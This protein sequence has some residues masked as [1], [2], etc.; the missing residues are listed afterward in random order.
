MRNSSAKPRAAKR[1]GKRDHDVFGSPVLDAMPDLIFRMNKEG[2]YLNFKPSKELE[3][4]VPPSEFLGRKMSDVLPSDVAEEGMALIERAIET[5]KTQ[6]YEYQLPMGEVTHTYEARI[7]ALDND[8]VLVI[9]RDISETRPAKSVASKPTAQPKNSYGLTTREFAVL[10]LL[11]GGLTDKE[12]GRQLQISP[13][14]ARKHVAN[15]RRKMGAPSRTAAGVR[16][17]REGLAK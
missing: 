10:R 9:V 7:V 13:E 5:G 2:R 15:L 16:A 14:T 12:I 4:Y 11:T 1:D 3:P 8:D 17:V 6:R